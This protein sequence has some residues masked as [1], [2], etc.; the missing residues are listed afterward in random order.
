MAFTR[1]MS[2]AGEVLGVRLV[3]HLI[4]GTNRRW[5]SLRRRGGW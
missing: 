3:D 2:E 5:I 1:R 4:L